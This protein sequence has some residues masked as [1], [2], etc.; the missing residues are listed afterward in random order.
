MEGPRNKRTVL[1][2]SSPLAEAIR[3]Q[4]GHGVEPTLSGLVFLV[5]CNGTF[6]SAF[7]Y[8]NGFIVTNSHVLPASQ[9]HQGFIWIKGGRKSL[10]NSFVVSFSVPN[11]MQ[12][13][14]PDVTLLK[15]PEIPSS[16]FGASYLSLAF[17]HAQGDLYSVNFGGPVEG[18]HVAMKQSK[19]I[20]LE[21]GRQ[22]HSWMRN[23]CFITKGA[24]GSPLFS[25]GS[26][27]KWLLAGISVGAIEGVDGKWSESLAIPVFQ[28]LQEI[29]GAFVESGL[30]VA[31]NDFFACYDNPEKDPNEIAKSL[32]AM[33][34]FWQD[35]SGTVDK[36]KSQAIEEISSRRIL[37]SIAKN[38]RCR[39]E[40]SLFG[41]LKNELPEGWESKVGACE[42]LHFEHGTL[43]NLEW[44]KLAFEETLHR[45]ERTPFFIG[46]LNEAK[47]SL[48]GARRVCL[49]N[50]KCVDAEMVKAF[51]DKMFGPV[52]IGYF[53]K[54]ITS[55]DWGDFD[56]G[57][58]DNLVHLGHF[59]SVIMQGEKEFC[60][61][62][63]FS[64]EFMMVE[65]TREAKTRIEH[66]FAPAQLSHMGRSQ[67]KPANSSEWHSEELYCF[68]TLVYCHVV[69]NANPTPHEKVPINSVR[70]RI[71]QKSVPCQNRCQKVFAAFPVLCAALFGCKA[72]AITV[73]HN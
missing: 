55:N 67:K 27:G 68:W 54:K 28:G 15:I 72:V 49:K 2:Y 46:V 40:A 62:G 19:G 56:T 16:E 10:A 71:V 7:H 29:C 39:I 11:V 64:N 36:L 20:V 1:H 52:E 13:D 41:V 34:S 23:S 8:G 59:D 42:F 51:S 38:F 57:G 21:S 18:G 14:A 43:Y 45:V 65:G 44:S 66:P 3:P 5:E 4:E 32:L 31:C 73:A 26:N 48:K 63:T 33:R 30:L 60:I 12:F 9:A 17:E 58:K 37:A 53:E 69:V 25:K 50:F 47:A 24:S 6:G 70:L 61:H 35:T 22:S